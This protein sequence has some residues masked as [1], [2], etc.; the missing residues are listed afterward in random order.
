MK[1]IIT[2]VFV[3]IAILF[4][5]IELGAKGSSSLANINKN[6]EKE[7]KAVSKNLNNSMVRYKECRDNLSRIRIVLEE[8]H[9]R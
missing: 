9:R 4:I 2:N 7:I 3:K 1:H 8:I 5:G 6:L